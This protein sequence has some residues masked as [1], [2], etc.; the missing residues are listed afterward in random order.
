[1]CIRDRIRPEQIFEALRYLRKQQNPYYNFY[2]DKET[3]MA[4]CRIKDERGLRLLE[5]DRDDIEED[6]GVPTK[7]ELVEV[8][9]QAVGDSDEGEDEMEIAVEE[10][11]EDIQNDP[12]RRQHFHYNE[13]VSYTH[14]TLPTILLV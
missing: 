11:E 10:E 5:D 8:E 13:S 9:D 12:V 4:R 14:L 2:D 7:P 3:Y 1:M 6:L